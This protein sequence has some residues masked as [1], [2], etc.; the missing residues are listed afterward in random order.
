MPSPSTKDETPVRRVAVVLNARSGTQQAELRRNDLTE[1][2]GR[3]DVAAEFVEV[4]DA[5]AVRAVIGNHASGCDVVVAAGGDG[6]INTVANALAAARHTLAGPPPPL[7]IVAFGTF[8]YVARRYQVGESVDDAVRTVV[9][10]R[11]IGI[12]AGEVSGHLFLNNCSL[13]L[14]T[15]IIDAR[16]RHKGVFGRSQL[17]ALVSGLVTMLSSHARPRVRIAQDGRQRQLRASL[18][19]VGANPLQLTELDP[20]IAQSVDDG[21]LALVVVRAIDLRRLVGFAW[22]ALTGAVIEAPEIE[23]EV[24][25][26]LT[27]ALRSRRARVVV[28]GELLDLPGT[29]EVRW[30]RDALRLRVPIELPASAAAEPPAARVSAS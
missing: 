4:A 12:A 11:T 17:V 3:L 5:D 15:S 29:L 13:G 30:H 26:A 27:L 24:V 2:F 16:E 6:T 7:G 25:Q 18:V 1:A 23:A 9:A 14:Y 8:N 28:D 10:G 20:A 19:F 21:A 22:R